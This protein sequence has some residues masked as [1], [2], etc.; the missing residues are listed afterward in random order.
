MTSATDARTN[1]AGSPRVTD[2]ATAP[3]D[4]GGNAPV[5]WMPRT[6]YPLSATE[7]DQQAPTGEEFEAWAELAA[8]ARQGWAEEN[9]Y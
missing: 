3:G 5:D 1:L 8:K 7:K 2:S 9:P 6:F 4:T